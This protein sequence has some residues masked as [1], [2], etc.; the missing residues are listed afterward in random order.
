MREDVLAKTVGDPGG[1]PARILDAAEAVFAEH[2]FVGTSTRE[3]ARRAGVPFGA[4]HYHW[5]SK[6][7]LW[8]AVFR[9]VME[10]ARETILHTFT[11]GGSIGELL[12]NLVDAFLEYFA[13]RRS[14]TRL[15]YRTALE[16]RD[17][18]VDSVH[19][20][21]RDLERL[22]LE[23]HAMLQPQSVAD[24]RVTIFVIANAF[25]ASIAD[26]ASQ[27]T[28]LG[29]TVFIEGPARERLRCELKR[30]ARAAFGAPSDATGG[31]G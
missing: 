26:E 31:P 14:V 6:K 21:F 1:T 25:I 18:H 28:F 24:I 29:G 15:C 4:L 13:A 30:L 11:P 17:P 19:G 8:E 23:I 16:P 12:D 5:G 27:E 9:R 2:G 7:E 20:M 10:R 22:G 3:I